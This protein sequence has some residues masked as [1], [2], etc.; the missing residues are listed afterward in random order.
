V[1]LP[2][3]VRGLGELTAL[4]PSADITVVLN[5]VRSAAAGRAPERALKLAWDRFGPELGIGHLLPW[6]SAAA[7][8]TLNAGQLLLEAAPDSALRAAVTEIVCAPVQRLRRSAVG[9]ATA[10]LRVSR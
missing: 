4:L 5:K 2:R 1:G 6:D 9:R 10:R 3:L 7:D 8:K